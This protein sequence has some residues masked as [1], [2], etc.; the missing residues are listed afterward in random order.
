MTGTAVFGDLVGQQDVVAE[1]RRAAGGRSS[2]IVRSG[3]TPPVAHLF[4]PATSL[5]GWLRPRPW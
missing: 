4:S 3:S 5:T 1:L 2:R